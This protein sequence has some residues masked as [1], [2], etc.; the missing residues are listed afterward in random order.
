MIQKLND[1][2]FMNLLFV[3]LPND[4]AWRLLILSDA[5]FSSRE[6]MKKRTHYGHLILLMVDEE[7]SNEG[8]CHILDAPSRRTPE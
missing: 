4:K 3:K 6:N 7:G 8:W 5:S 1:T 2:N